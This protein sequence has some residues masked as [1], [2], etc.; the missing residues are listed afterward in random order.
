M[1]SGLTIMI[2][3]LGGMAGQAPLAALVEAAGWRGTLLGAA[4]FGALLGLVIWLV[5]RDRPPGSEAATAA[6]QPA[7]S[8]LAACAAV[9]GRGQNWLLALVC[10]AMTAPLLAFGALWGVAWLMQT[11]GLERPE[12]AAAASLVLLGWAVGGPLMGALSDR[13]GRRK[14]L[15]LAGTALSLATLAAVLH[16]PAPPLA[17][18]SALLLLN[19]VGSGAMVIGFAATREGNPG[20]LVGAAYSI[21]NCAVVATGA[22]FQPLVGWLLDLSWDGQALAGARIYSEAAYQTA[23]SSLLVFLAVGLAA[24]LFLRET[25]PAVAGGKEA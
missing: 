19:G 13:I 16:L 22:V 20:H 24:G 23:L 21:V 9:F 14:P 12:A 10:A 7:G 8:F 15:L 18:L 4:A 25:G 17:L 5:V 3:M 11:R 1:I 6:A 2:G